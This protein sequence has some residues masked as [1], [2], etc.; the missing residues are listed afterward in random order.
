MKVDHIQTSIGQHT[1][2]ALVTESS[3][4]M[5]SWNRNTAAVSSTVISKRPTCV[6]YDTAQ[7]ATGLTIRS[8]YVGEVSNP[9]PVITQLLTHALF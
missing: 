2:V 6:K 1:G 7:F 4:N 8:R 5:P 3:V 9:L